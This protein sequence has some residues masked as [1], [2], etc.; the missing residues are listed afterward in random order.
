MPKGKSRGWCFVLHPYDDVERDAWEQAIDPPLMCPTEYD[1]MIYQVELGG[2]T[3]C[4]HLQGFIYVKDG[5]SFRSVKRTIGRDDIHLEKAKGSVT[6]N[7]LYCTKTPD[8]DLEAMTLAGPWEFGNRPAQGVGVWSEVRELVRRHASDAMIIDARPNVAPAWR[9]VEQI[10]HTILEDPV[11]RDVCTYFLWGTPGGG[12]TTRTRRNFPGAYWIIGKYVERSSF[13]H[14]H[15]Q[16]TLVLDEWR[17]GE[18]GMTDMNK[19]LDRWCYY[20]DCRYQN[21]CARWTTVIILSN[22]DPSETYYGN[23]YRMSFLRRIQNI[24]YTENF[25]DVINW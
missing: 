6:Q 8:Y 7:I 18:W 20:I 17:D 19:I 3:M 22:M 14:Y 16:S 24:F 11:E 15:A 9:G 5:I 10:R 4:V 23:P 13:D 2:E 25:D 12:K 1:Y 21:P